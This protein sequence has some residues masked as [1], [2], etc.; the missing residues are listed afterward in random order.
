MSRNR[1]KKKNRQPGVNGPFHCTPVAE[2]LGVAICEK[3]GNQRTSWKGNEYKTDG[4]VWLL[5][6]P[7][8]EEL[9]MIGLPS[10]KVAKDFIEDLQRDGRT[11][12]FCGFVEALTICKAP[13]AVIEAARGATFVW[14]AVQQIFV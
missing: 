6:K 5:K 9:E 12:E 4:K 11:K 10:E 2:Y 13:K 7:D 14:D 3:G 1:K 8:G